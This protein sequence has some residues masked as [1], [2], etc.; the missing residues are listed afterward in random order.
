LVRFAPEVIHL[1]RL[2]YT[3]FR[4]SLS[5]VLNRAEYRNESFLIHRRGRNSAMLIPC[6]ELKRLES[7]PKNIGPATLKG[8]NH[9]E[10]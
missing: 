2:T 5:E 1:E 3:E 10:L 4:V 7:K 6:E 8:A 9:R